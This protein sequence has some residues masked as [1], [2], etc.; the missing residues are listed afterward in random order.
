[1]EALGLAARFPHRLARFTAQCRSAGQ[2]KATPLLLH[3]EAGGYNC[4]HQDLYGDLAFPL[5][6][7]CFLSEPRAAYTGGEFLLVEQRPRA[8]SVGH[9]VRPGRGEALVF[10]TRWRPVKGSRGF[11][12]A[13]VKHG[14]S[15]V[16]SGT[17]YTLGVIYHD[18]R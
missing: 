16:L 4:L 8:Q 14:V 6:F 7:V 9:A 13:N 12:R 17:R 1:M 11:Y 15:P 10:T 2:D 18:A 3:Y 5:Q